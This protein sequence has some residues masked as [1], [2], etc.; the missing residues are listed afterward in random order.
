MTNISS[1]TQKFTNARLLA[2]QAVYAKQFSDESWDKITSRFLLGEAGGSVIVEGVAGRETVVELE[3]ADAKLFSKLVAEVA[4][5]SDDFDGVLRT[6]LSDKIDYDRLEVLL[7]CILKVG[8]AEFYVNAALDTPIIIN[9]YADMTKAFFD[10]SE[11]RIV[12]AVLDKYAKV[13]RG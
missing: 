4:E 5:K 7:K 12:N 6:A 2:V 3:P 9:E 13:I 1:P 10:K 11:V 8:M